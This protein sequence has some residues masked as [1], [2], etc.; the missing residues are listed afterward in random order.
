MSSTVTLNAH[1]P[2]QQHLVTHLQEH[3]VTQ[4]VQSSGWCRSF[5]LSQQNIIQIEPL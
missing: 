3:L 2:L 4:P 1:L 5:L